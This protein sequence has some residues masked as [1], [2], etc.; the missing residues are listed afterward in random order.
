M[1]LSPPP[2]YTKSF[3]A[4]AIGVGCSLVLLAVNRH[5][6]PIAG[7]SQHRFPFGGCYR[8]GTKSAIYNRPSLPSA[9]GLSVSKLEIFLGVLLLSAVVLILSSRK[10][11]R[12]HV[13]G[14]VH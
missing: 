3:L 2:D 9:Q 6:Y 10:G 12:C 13:C 4:V 8:D 11:S 7:D 14:Q 5:I 1:S